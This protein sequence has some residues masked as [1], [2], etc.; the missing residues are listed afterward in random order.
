MIAG[1]AKNVVDLFEPY[2]VENIPFIND[3][4]IAPM[5]FIEAAQDNCSVVN[6][7]VVSGVLSDKSTGIAGES[8][9][10]LHPWLKTMKLAE[11]KCVPIILR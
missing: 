5:L 6:G 1:R 4:L 7:P 9:P 8:Q 11:S 3:P 2:N 10:T